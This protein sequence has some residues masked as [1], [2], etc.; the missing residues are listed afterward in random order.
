MLAAPFSPVTDIK[1]VCQKERYPPGYFMLTKTVQGNDGQLFDSTWRQKGKRYLCFARQGGQNVIE[2]LTVID[3]DDRVPAGF[4]ALTKAHDDDDKALRKH[5]LCFKIKASKTA[6]SAVFDIV[7]I[8]RNK[9]ETAPP[10]YKL[11]T[12]EVNNLSVCFKAAPMTREPPG[13]PSV[14]QNPYSVPPQ[15][16]WYGQAPVPSPQQHQL[17]YQALPA[18]SAKPGASSAIEGLPFEVNSKFE[19]LWKKSGPVIPAMQSLS[20]SD[21]DVKYNYDFSKE[22]AVT[23]R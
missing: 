16:Q 13:P 8:N 7:L 5:F 21:I 23:S 10:G 17:G 3:E 1:I 18:V 19:M 4:T 20:V 14:H 12:N 22:Q 2:D 11:I 6:V 15:N 9:G